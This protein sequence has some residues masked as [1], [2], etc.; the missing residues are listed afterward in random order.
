[1]I[2]HRVPV[3]PYEDPWAT[4]LAQRLA[5]MCQGRRRVAYY[6]DVPDSSTFRYRG[7]NMAQALALDGAGPWRGGCFYRADLAHRHELAQ[8]ADVLVVCRAGYDHTLAALLAA[9]RAE[10]KPVLYDVDD[11]V[12][13]PGFIHLLMDTLCVDKRQPE[14]WRFWQA[15]LAAQQATLQHCDASITTNGHL[16]GLLRQ[17]RG[18]DVAIVPNFMNQQQLDVSAQ[19]YR[20]K[21][22]GACVDDGR[23]VFGYFSGSPSHQHDL[24]IVEPA[25]SRL[26]QADPRVHLMLVGHIE[27]GQALRACPGRIIRQPFQDFVNLQRLIGTV[28]YNLMPLQ[29]NVFTDAKSAL[30]YFEAAAVGTVSLASPSYNYSLAI[31]HGRTGYLAQAHQWDRLLQQVLSQHAT[32]ATLAQAAHGDAMA[33]HGWQGRARDIEQ[34]L[35]QLL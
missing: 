14:F 22:G 20:N 26:M 27:P 35:D 8:Q 16:A 2:D 24:A 18:H 10:G 31:E 23:I 6:Y 5:G 12:F 17:V 3:V 29:A 1:M 28:H 21:Q 30:K 13:D 25:L 32:S 19:V 9:F 7:Y 33:R 15:T 34:A 4:P 11:F